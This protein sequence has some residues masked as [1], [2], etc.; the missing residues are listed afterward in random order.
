MPLGTRKPNP[1]QRKTTR[2][3]EALVPRAQEAVA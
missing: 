1:A 2:E 3:D